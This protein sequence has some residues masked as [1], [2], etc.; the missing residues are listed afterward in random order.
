M[1]IELMSKAW[2]MEEI[3]S[4]QKLVMLE[5]CDNAS[6]EG[7]CYLSIVTIAK[8]CSLTDRAVRSAMDFLESNHLVNIQERAGSN[9]FHI[10]INRLMDWPSYKKKQ[11]I[12]G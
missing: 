3:S 6:D 12:K 11:L 1:S 8:K 10:N 7:I 9:I 5:L 4:T 2:A